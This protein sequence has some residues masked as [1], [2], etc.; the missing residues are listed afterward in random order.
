MTDYVYVTTVTTEGRDVYVYVTRKFPARE[1]M[2][3]KV[4]EY[5]DAEERE[6]YQE[7]CDVVTTLCK[8][9]D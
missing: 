5:E 2:I 9:E 7:T 3:D 1:D 8:V 6:F 4:W